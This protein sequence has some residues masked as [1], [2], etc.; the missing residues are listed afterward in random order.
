VRGIV[1]ILLRV[2]MSRTHQSFRYL[3]EVRRTVEDLHWMAAFHLPTYLTK[4]LNHLGRVRVR[5]SG[6]FGHHHLHYPD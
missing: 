2:R 6:V 4:R 1:K 3:T 5:I